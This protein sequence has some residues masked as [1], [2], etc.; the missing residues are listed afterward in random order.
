MTE[1]NHDLE[2]KPTEVTENQTGHVDIVESRDTPEMPV[3]TSKEDSFAIS[4]LSP[5]PQNE[6]GT[7]EQNEIVLSES[8]EDENSPEH[9]LNQEV[10]ISFDEATNRR[11]IFSEEEEPEIDLEDEIDLVFKSFDQL[12]PFLQ[13]ICACFEEK[14][15]QMLL[16]STLTVISSVL[17]NVYGLYNQQ[18]VYPN[19]FLYVLGKAGSGKAEMRWTQK[20]ISNIQRSNKFTEEANDSLL[21][22]LM[23]KGYEGQQL[24]TNRSIII[25]A[26]SSTAGFL[27]LLDQRDG[28]GMLFE[29]EGDTLVNIFKTEFGNYSDMLRKSFHH[30]PI[31]SYRK[32]DAVMIDIQEP[33]LSVLISSTPNQLKGIM[34]S[35]ENG[36][37]SR[38]M[39]CS[40]FPVREFSDVFTV[41]GNSK[42][43]IF[44]KGADELFVLYSKLLQIE[45]IEITLTAT[46]RT[47]FLGFFNK[48]KS[49]LTN[50]FN[51]DLDAT[52]NRMGVITFRIMM[53]LIVTRN[54]YETLESTFECSDTDFE[55]ALELAEIL[56]YNANKTI[57][58]L[59][60]Q[61][62]DVQSEAKLNLFKVLPPNEFTTK[63][64]KEIAVRYNLQVSEREIDRFLKSACFE[65]LKRGIYRKVA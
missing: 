30:E 15:K 23:D 59:P 49:I 5:V 17:P 8:S 21:A 28:I 31:T 47:K 60:K 3:N 7:N 4:P 62:Q 57:A 9:Q 61:E 6:T 29:T 32:T 54:M 43:V 1:Q 20:L 65:K 40:T 37:F 26:N 2:G 19:L 10:E 34:N 58:Q 39:F 44:Q 36:L 56:L 11:D 18:T 64:A 12:P 48:N 42:E 50:M 52:V 46:Q 35:A 25:P 27:Q 22:K 63:E 33:K 55:I 51:E 24:P 13:E 53:I 16:L 45:G 38:F 14:D 41:K